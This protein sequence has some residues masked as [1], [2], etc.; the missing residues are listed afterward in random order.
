MFVILRQ[1]SLKVKPF[2]PINVKDQLRVD[3][4]ATDRLLHLLKFR[5]SSYFKRPV[6]SPVSEVLSIN[7]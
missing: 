4:A 7:D 1:L 5:K 2:L 3:G 6:S